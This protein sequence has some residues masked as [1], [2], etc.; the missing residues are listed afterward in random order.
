MDC[1]E[2]W[3]S[4]VNFKSCLT[5]VTLCS[6]MYILCRFQ[7]IYQTPG[8]LN[9]IW[10]VKMISLMEVLTGRIRKSKRNPKTLQIP[11]GTS[12]IKDILRHSYSNLLDISLHSDRV[13]LFIVKQSPPIHQVSIHFKLNYNSVKLSRAS[14]SVGRSNVK[15]TDIQST[16]TVLANRK[17]ESLRRQ[18]A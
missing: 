4:Q 15:R 17:T 12:W 16:V 5:E 1:H 13:K 7:Y 6:L 10:N 18:S 8:N 9:L 14:S 2:L 3:R 11:K